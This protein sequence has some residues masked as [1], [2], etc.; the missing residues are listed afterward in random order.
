[1]NPCIKCIKCS[2]AA[3][4][5]EDAG[6]VLGT[7]GTVS[8]GSG[9]AEACD[10]D[11]LADVV[12]ATDAERGTDAD[13]RGEVPGPDSRGNLNNVLWGHGPLSM[14]PNFTSE[15]YRVVNDAYA[16]DT[17]E[18]HS[19]IL[20]YLYSKTTRVHRAIEAISEKAVR[21]L[22]RGRFGVTRRLLLMILENFSFMFYTFDTVLAKL[23]LAC[24]EHVTET[25]RVPFE[26]VFRG[27]AQTLARKTYK[28]EKQNR[29]LFVR[30]CGKDFDFDQGGL[31]RAL[32]GVPELFVFDC[33]TKF[34]HF[35]RFLRSR[36]ADREEF[37]VLMLGNTNLINAPA[38]LDHLVYEGSQSDFDV[39]AVMEQHVKNKFLVLQSC[40]SVLATLL[41]RIPARARGAD[42][43]RSGD[44]RDVARVVAWGRTVLGAAEEQAEES[45]QSFLSLF[46]A[47]YS[48]RDNRVLESENAVPA[49]LAGYFGAF[50][51]QAPTVVYRL[52]LKKIFQGDFI[53]S[54]VLTTYSR[55]YQRFMLGMLLRDGR[56]F[57][58]PKL[59]LLLG[60]IFGL[61]E[62][63]RETV[64]EMLAQLSDDIFGSDE[65]FNTAF[66]AR[67]RVMLFVS[68]ND[69]LRDFLARTVETRPS[70]R[71]VRLLE[72]QRSKAE[73]NYGEKFDIKSDMVLYEKY[74]ESSVGKY[75][76]SLRSSINLDKAG[77]NRHSRLRFR[78]NED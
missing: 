15:T 45:T 16:K 78:K 17:E 2:G 23:L 42:A 32:L 43:F 1:M 14:F 69:A 74:I 63:F 21:E 60:E 22:R 61:V 68:K 66:E 18:T 47:F 77:L 33:E 48:V 76:K 35:N 75:G 44:H 58:D 37:V 64:V 27:Y 38:M 51:A 13:L 8:G 53:T 30:L 36:D 59:L 19:Y 24:L 39:V 72:D 25:T 57:H 7:R 10:G 62:C 4:D 34:A 50:L 31:V 54:P 9:N 28:N 40:N 12:V 65:V 70:E 55:T 73:G 11:L 52:V 3:A 56:S 20:T 46:K 26:D 71:T 6:D 29:E 5:D 41:A 49:I 67:L